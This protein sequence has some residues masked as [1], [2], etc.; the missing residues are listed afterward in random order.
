MQ[1]DKISFDSGLTGNSF[2][3]MKKNSTGKADF[4]GGI[5]KDVSCRRF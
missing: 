3:G 1:Y 2:P 4:Q 5:A